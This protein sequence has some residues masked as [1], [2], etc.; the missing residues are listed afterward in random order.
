MNKIKKNWNTL[1][2]ESNHPYNLR[3][4]E[5]K[6]TKNKTNISTINVLYPEM[7]EEQILRINKYIARKIKLKFISSILDFGSGTGNFLLYCQKSK[8]IKKVSIEINHRFIKHQ[9]KI[10]RLTKFINPKN[11]LNYLKNI[12][13]NS[14]DAILCNSVFQYLRKKDTLKVIDGLIRIAKKDILILD[15][16][17]LKKKTYWENM[18]M[19]RYNL[20]SK[21][22]RERYK[23]YNISFFSKKEISYFLKKKKNIT[24][25]IED[26]VRYLKDHKFGF[27]VHIKKN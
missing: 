13:S 26:N 12:Q 27:M 5:L 4:N 22:F 23:F 25:K 2:N 11:G 24:F 3:L 6:F 8:K 7:S 17:N 16:K 15:I 20:N 21:T 18:Q 19:K 9:K 14:I 1:F 10:L